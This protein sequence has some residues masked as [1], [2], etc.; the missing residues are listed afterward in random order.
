[1]CAQ[2]PPEAYRAL[3]KETNDTAATTYT[4]AFSC[5]TK[6][7][8]EGLEHERKNNV[9]KEVDDTILDPLYVL[10][11][12]MVNE[13]WSLDKVLQGPNAQSWNDALKYEI[14]QLKKLHTWSI[15]DRPTN[16]PVIPC[17]EVLQEKTNTDEVVSQCV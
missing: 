8:D 17:T 2:L 13:P 10:T 9:N 7:D 15:I 12:S 1:M 14:N 4:I 16:K 5:D 3:A 6:L 11:G